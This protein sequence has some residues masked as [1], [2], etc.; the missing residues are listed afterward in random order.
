MNDLDYM[1]RAAELALRAKG[2]TSPNPIVGAVIVKNGRILAE[3]WHKFCGGDHAEVA[4]LKKLKG[5]ARGATLYVTLEPCFHYG[6]TPPCVETIIQ[7]GIKKVTIG[8]KD[9]NPLTNGQSIRKLRQ[10]GIKV[11]VGVLKEEVERMNES[12]VKYIRHR[13]PFVVAK[14]AQTLDG[15]IATAAGQSKWITSEK[16]RQFAHELRNQFDAILVGIN[17]V[18]KDDPRLNAADKRKKIKKIVLDSSLKISPKAKLFAG[19]RPADCFVVTTRRAPLT[20]VAALRRKGVNVL[21]APARG[22]RVDLGWLFRT[23]AAQQVTSV[24]IEGGAQTIGQALKA[25]LVDKMFVFIAPKLIGDQNALSSVD[26][27]LASN[28]NQAIRLKNVRSQSIGSDI[29]LEGYVN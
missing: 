10:A 3:G 7:S 15:K 22:N 28:I 19:T 25:G 18:I 13:M 16:T 24:L 11:E 21:V 1:I 5:A 12:F 17:T 9:P 26:G 4:A 23:L 6:R 27:L 14:T 20:K 8:M 29:F 2:F